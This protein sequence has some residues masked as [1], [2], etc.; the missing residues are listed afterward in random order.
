MGVELAAIALATA[1]VA[2][3]LPPRPQ[4]A[5]PGNVR[6]VTAR[7]SGSEARLGEPVQVTVIAVVPPGHT[8][9]FPDSLASGGAAG[10]ESAAPVRW[11]AAP[12]P[13]DSVEVT[14]AWSVRSFLEGGRQVPELALLL[15]RGN[16]GEP[17]L[18]GAR[19]DVGRW[20][21]VAA[22]DPA[23]LSRRPV[24]PGRVRVQPVLPVARPPEGFTPRPPLDALGGDWSRWV[25][26]T[27]LGAAL[28][29]LSAGAGVARRTVARL[30]GWL[31]RWLAAG[32][33][34]RHPPPPPPSPLERVLA[35][36]DDALRAGLHRQGRPEAFYTRIVHALRRYLAA[37]EPGYRPALTDRELVRRLARGEEPFA[38]LMRHQEVVRFW[39][40]RPAADDA[41]T[42]LGVLRAWLLE[43]AGPEPAGAAEG[44]ER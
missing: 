44:G 43:H 11:S 3:T 22:L 18:P 36:L 8:L 9:Y 20:A 23:T 32:R 38:L 13:G 15:R 6:L 42:D 34:R 26:A 7:L 24:L 33:A 37:V 27:A 12:A 14:L 39:V 4:E 25:V 30:E 2:A 10:W 28:L 17:A 19:V 35:E 29:V 40:E 1:A 31:G 41:E 5:R 21:E 16:P